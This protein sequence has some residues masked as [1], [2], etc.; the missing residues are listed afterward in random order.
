MNVIFNNDS[1]F[2]TLTVTLHNLVSGFNDDLLTLTVLDIL[3]SQ[4]KISISLSTVWKKL[5]NIDEIAHFLIV[6][7]KRY[8][9]NTAKISFLSSLKSMT[10]SS[11]NCQQSLKVHS[12]LLAILQNISAQ[13]DVNEKNKILAE[14]IYD[15]S[16]CVS[17]TDYKS[18]IYYEH[19]K[20]LKQDAYRNS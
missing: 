5:L 19:L 13:L 3:V 2:E 15:M 1:I 6:C 10:Q 18:E 8:Q 4:Y 14:K 17:D 20:M 12:D 11:L 7:E 16:L 9:I